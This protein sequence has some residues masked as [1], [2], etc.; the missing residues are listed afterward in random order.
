MTP[1]RRTVLKGVAAAAVLANLP[2]PLASAA[3][4]PPVVGPRTLA[5]TGSSS[6]NGWAVNVAADAGGSVWTRPVS[7][8]AKRIAVAVGDADAILVHVVRRFHYEVADL[9]DGD[10]V[11]FRTA[12]GLEG[13]QLNH[14]SGSAIDVLP[15]HYRPGVKD[16]FYPAQLAVVRDILAEC[17]GVVA[18]GGDFA[19]PDEGHFEIALPP[20]DRRVTELAAQIRRWNTTPGQGAGVLLDPAA[21][22]G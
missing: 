9:G 10:V 2:G 7:G 3:A 17:C 14:A 20:Q 11:G 15:E 1:T 22:G 16:Q 4:R 8:A 13:H 5:F 19:T 21:R 12:G 6:P 18:W